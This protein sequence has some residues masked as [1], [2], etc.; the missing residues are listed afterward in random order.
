MPVADCSRNSTPSLS[1]ERVCVWVRRPAT[2]SSLCS[3][4]SRRV[5]NSPSPRRHWSVLFCCCA[6]LNVRVQVQVQQDYGVPS[7]LFS[8]PRRNDAV[9]GRFMTT[10][11]P[12]VH[13]MTARC[14]VWCVRARALSLF[15][16]FLHRSTVLV[17]DAHVTMLGRRLK[18]PVGLARKVLDS[19]FKF[20]FFKTCADVCCQVPVLEKQAAT[21]TAAVD[22][23]N[24]LVSPLGVLT[25]L[26]RSLTCCWQRRSSRV[27]ESSTRSPTQTSSQCGT[28]AKQIV[29]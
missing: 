18:S 2:I 13:L 8:Y 28:L 16:Q 10:D 12:V 4:G 26:V 17:T 6:L 27:N 9:T 11:A 5:I 7:F 25:V 3:P 1:F 22:E 15:S 24:S 21:K 19:K 29:S 20:V 23:V 14:V